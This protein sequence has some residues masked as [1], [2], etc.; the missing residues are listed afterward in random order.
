MQLFF[1][2]GEMS[3]DVIVRVGAGVRAAGDGYPRG[4]ASRGVPAG[5]ARRVRRRQRPARAAGAV[6]AARRPATLA[7]PARRA[8][9]APAFTMSRRRH[10][11]CRTRDRT[12]QLPGTIL[13]GA[14]I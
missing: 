14:Y 13:C 7:P 6:R 10:H 4:D 8:H 1:C 2:H 11:C 3:L 9:S 5:R 12:R